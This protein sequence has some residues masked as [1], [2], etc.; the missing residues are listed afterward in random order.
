VLAVRQC[1]K[2]RLLLLLLLLLSAWK[3]LVELCVFCSGPC[4]W[5]GPRPLLLTTQMYPPF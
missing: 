4:W 2:K 1:L 3:F 5:G